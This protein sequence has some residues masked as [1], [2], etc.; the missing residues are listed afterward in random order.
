MHR[1]P[2]RRP[3][4]GDAWTHRTS[5]G[6]SPVAVHCGRVTRETIEERARE[7][8]RFVQEASAAPIADQESMRDLPADRAV[9]GRLATESVVL[10]KNSRGVLPLCPNSDKDVAII[11]SNA[12]L[13]AACGGGSA[14]L[15]PYYTGSVYQGIR[16]QLSRHVTSTTSPAYLR[17]FYCQSSPTRKSQTTP[18]IPYYNRHIQRT[19]HCCWERAFRLPDHPRHNLLAHG[20]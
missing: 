1:S 7:V 8:L 16:A 17:T 13:P 11:E 9:N 2:Q 20:R 4:P 6:T 19:P 3:G 10:L 15:R 5:R 12:K 18:A 14:S